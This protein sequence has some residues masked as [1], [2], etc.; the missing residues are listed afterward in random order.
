MVVSSQR[1]RS[2]PGAW[3]IFMRHRIVRIVPLYW[4][5]TTIKWLLVFIFADLALRSNLDVDFVFRSYLFL[6]LVDS[7]GHFRPLLPVG[8]TLTYEFLF[9]LMFAL[10]LALR[11]NVL[12]VVVPAFA[13]F[14][15]LALLR[16][17]RWPASAII[18]N[19]IV[20][21]FVFGV[22]LAQLTLRQWKLPPMLGAA[23]A[24]MG[25][26]FILIV[27]QV[28]ENLRP[29]TWGLPA[30]A[31]VAGAVSLEARVAQA[32]P[33]WLQALGDASYS[34]YLTHGLVLPLLGIWVMSLHWTTSSAL[35]FTI[36]ACLIVASITGWV[37]Y[38]SIER[39]MTLWLKRRTAKRKPST[40]NHGTHVNS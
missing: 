15:V 17:E 3:R 39:P 8:W 22:A 25:F 10:A 16:T 29:L 30:F 38:V 12:R 7:A 34:I 40:L 21:E 26:C 11:V 1:F 4:L 27:P 37:V 5:M 6:P 36:I 13:V 20:V 2:E 32:L 24:V 19:T 35:A 31:I 9:Y 14:I 18:F 23:L 33:R 28:S